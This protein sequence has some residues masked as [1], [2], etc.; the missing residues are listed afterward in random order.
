MY[1]QKPIITTKN[2]GALDLLK[3]TAFFCDLNYKSVMEQLEYVY[4][5]IKTIK[6]E[7]DLDDFNINRY[8]DRLEALYSSCL[9]NKK[10]RMI[11]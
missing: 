11:S 6:I 4:H 7:Y 1:F 5:N 2:Y 9:N 8:H 10:K 3:H